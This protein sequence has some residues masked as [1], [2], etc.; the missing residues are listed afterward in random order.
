MA[1]RYAKSM[2]FSP[3]RHACQRSGFAIRTARNAKNAIRN[4]SSA[5]A[6]VRQC[7]LKYAAIS[8]RMRQSMSMDISTSAAI[9]SATLMT[10]NPINP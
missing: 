6:M 3:P 9:D 2:G 4:M 10:L 1:L 8:S 7:V 5:I